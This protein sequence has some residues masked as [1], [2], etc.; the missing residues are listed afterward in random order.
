MRAPLIIAGIE[1]SLIAM[2]DFEQSIEPIGGSATRRMANGSAF[3]MTAWEKHRIVLSGSGWVPAP[4]L[5]VDYSQPFVI[6]LPIPEA[7]AIGQALPAGWQS[8]SAPWG[9]YTVTDQSGASVRMIYPKMTVVSAGPKKSNGHGASP[10]WDLTC[11][12][13]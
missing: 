13:A 6:E 3:K 2:L 10:A 9:E 4:L 8:R 11:E 1:I 7:F 12:V 5:A